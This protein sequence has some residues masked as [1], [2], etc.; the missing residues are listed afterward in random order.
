MHAARR[1]EKEHN[2]IRHAQ[3]QLHVGFLYG[4]EPPQ[5]EC[6]LSPKTRQHQLSQK[7]EWEGAGNGDRSVFSSSSYLQKGSHTKVI[8]QIVVLLVRLLPQ[9]RPPPPPKEAVFL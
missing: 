5:A 1:D 9:Q 3:C 7:R 2:L 8:C 6:T 4:L